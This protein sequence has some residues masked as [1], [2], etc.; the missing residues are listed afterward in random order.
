[1]H[2]IVPLRKFHFVSYIARLVYISPQHYRPYWLYFIAFAVVIA[3]LI[4]YFWHS[5][6]E[7]CLLSVSYHTKNCS[8]A[9]EQGALNPTSPAYVKRRGALPIPDDV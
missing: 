7:R 2:R 5:T 6:R 4:T 8:P 1:M 3:G 9:E